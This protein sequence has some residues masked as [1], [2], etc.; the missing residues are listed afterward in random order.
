MI[1]SKK[2]YKTFSTDDQGRAHS[3]NDEPAVIYEDGTREWHKHGIVHREFGPAIESKFS[4]S[5]VRNGGYHRTDGPAIIYHE[6]ANPWG[7][8]YFIDSKEI[9]KEEFDRNYLIIHLREYE[10]DDHHED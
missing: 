4:S 2:A 9:S 10:E 6:G 3:V 1:S 8:R 5:W 7:N